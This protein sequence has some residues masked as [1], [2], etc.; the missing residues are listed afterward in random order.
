MSDDYRKISFSIYEWNIVAGALREQSQNVGL[1]R[2]VEME[3]LADWIE[4]KVNA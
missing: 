3:V 2:R 1:I 4:D